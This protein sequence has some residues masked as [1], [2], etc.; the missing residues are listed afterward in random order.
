MNT[1]NSSVLLAVILFTTVLTSAVY[2]ALSSDANA[3]ISD[4]VAFSHTSSPKLFGHIDYAVYAP[5]DYIGSLS[6]PDKFVYCYQIFNNP[7]ST[8]VSSFIIS[9]DQDAAAYNP[10]YDAASASGVSGGINPT[11]YTLTPNSVSYFSPRNA[12]PADQ[13]SSVLLFTSDSAPTI[14]TG[15]VA[16]AL[17]GSI[18]VQLPTLVPEPTTLVLLALAAPAFIRTR[19]HKL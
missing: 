19:R 6:F 5:G 3:I 1:K 8:A 9:L 16:G 15:F 17:T 7:T 14:G 12:I 2:A 18:S 4:Q 11:A 13:H 10:T